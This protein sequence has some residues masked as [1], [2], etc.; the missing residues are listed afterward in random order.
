MTTN[1]HIEQIEEK[2]SKQMLTLFAVLFG[3]VFLSL[4]FMRELE[5]EK[6]M[7]LNKLESVKIELLKCEKPEVN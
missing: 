3:I 5:I 7:L 1:W 2:H 4:W 6:E